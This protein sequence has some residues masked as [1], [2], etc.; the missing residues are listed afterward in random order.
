MNRRRGRPRLPGRGIWC[1]TRVLGSRVS[2]ILGERDKQNEETM[3]GV[4]PRLSRLAERVLGRPVQPVER[5]RLRQLAVRAKPSQITRT[6]A[7]W[8]FG[9]P[10]RTVRRLQRQKNL[11][12]MIWR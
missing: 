10:D 7:G 8:R 3:T 5:D 2:T 9:L 11:G 6:L 12:K 1:N 4:I